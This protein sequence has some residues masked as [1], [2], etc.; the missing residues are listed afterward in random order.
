[1]NFE[2][3]VVETLKDD[4]GNEIKKGDC[5]IYT[6]KSK[7]QS[8]IARFNG[9]EKG[10]MIFTPFDCDCG[11]YTVQPKTIYTMYKANASELFLIN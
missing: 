8:F 2:R 10:Y 5:V 3:K 4:N 9:I 1:M 6:L 11:T 7:P